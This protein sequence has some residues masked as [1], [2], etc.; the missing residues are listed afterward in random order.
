ME[1]LDN[2]IKGHDK[3]QKKLFSAFVKK[4]LPHALL[5]V[6]P[7]GVGKKRTAWALA[8]TLLCEQSSP[9]CGECPS[10]RQIQKQES[11]SVLTVFP[12]TLRIRIHEVEGIT[13]FL[14]LKSQTPAQIVIIDEAHLLNLQAANSLLKIIEE[15]PQN[16]YFFLITPLPSHLPITLKSRLQQIR[17]QLLPENIIKELS[18]APDWMIRASNGRMDRLQQLQDKSELRQFALTLL[19]EILQNKNPFAFNFPSE[20]KDRKT[21]LF[22]ARCWQQL[23]RDSRFLQT[24]EKTPLIHGDQET[25]IRKISELSKGQLD[26]VIE[27]ALELEKNI[28]SYRDGLLCFEHFALSLHNQTGPSV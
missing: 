11:S 5:F 15:P 16:S 17:F 18:L 9:A 24:G 3:V 1:L 28:N 25:L 22:T 6:G 20:I 14:S 2:S 7:S 8:Q 19:N 13:K 12:E 23:L 26:T 27:S 21:A 10:C 4:R